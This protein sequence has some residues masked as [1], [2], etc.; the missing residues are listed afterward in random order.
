MIEGYWDIGTTRSNEGVE[1]FVGYM[2]D[3]KGGAREE[4]NLIRENRER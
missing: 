2:H 3:V 1:D 4:D